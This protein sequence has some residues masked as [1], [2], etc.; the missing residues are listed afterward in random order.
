M[1]CSH[2]NDTEEIREV[3]CGECLIESSMDINICGG[4]AYYECPLCKNQGRLE[5]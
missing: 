3:I 4:R 5:E 1:T 2:V